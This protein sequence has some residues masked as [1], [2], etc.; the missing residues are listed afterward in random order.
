MFLY[1]ILGYII[2]SLILFLFPGI[3]HKKKT[4]RNKILNHIA[5]RKD[6]KVI[7]IAHRGG[8]NLNY[9]S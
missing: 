5:Q 7:M 8:I 9:E 6:N 4:Y 3:I 1:I 2:I